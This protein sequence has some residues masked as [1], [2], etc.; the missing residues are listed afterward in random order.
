MTAYVVTYM[1]WT[2]DDD[3]ELILGYYCNYC[4]VK[5]AIMKHAS[6]YMS[7]SAMRA[8]IPE[9]MIDNYMRIIMDEKHDYI[10]EEIKIE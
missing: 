4:R 5:H 7:F 3:N 9:T 2:C 10:I 1:D 6:K 8:I